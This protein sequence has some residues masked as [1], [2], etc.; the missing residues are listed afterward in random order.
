MV[1]GGGG[2]G[3][4]GAVFNLPV[5]MLYRWASGM[6]SPFPVPHSEPCGTLSGVLGPACLRSL[7]CLCR[8]C[9]TTGGAGGGEGSGGGSPVCDSAK[10][11]MPSMIYSVGCF[12]VNLH[13]PPPP[14]A[15]AGVRMMACGSQKPG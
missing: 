11:I 6:K 7:T 15:G 3:G 1:G 4:G 14:P 5:H 2:G 13:R 12:A 9:I 10:C 8:W